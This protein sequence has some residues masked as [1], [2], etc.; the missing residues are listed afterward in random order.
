MVVAVLVAALGSA[1]VFLYTK[2]ADTRAEKKFDTD[3]GPRG[4]R[5]HQPRREDRGRPGRR[6]AGA[7]V[8]VQGRAPRRLPDHDRPAGRQRRARHHLPGRAD[9]R[10]EVGC[11]GRRAVVAPDPGRDDGSLDQP[12]RPRSRR[13]LRQPGLTG[14]CIRLGHR[15][16]QRPAVHPA[17]PGSGHRARRRVAPLPCRPPRR[18]RPAPR[19][20]SSCPAR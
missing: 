18:T 3:G 16:D 20:P 5:G 14:G 11:L 4:H 7:E 15:P 6:Q 19:R 12:D 13:G 8:G 2:G 9:H 10:R 1:L 17:P